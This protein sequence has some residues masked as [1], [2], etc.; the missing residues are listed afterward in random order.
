VTPKWTLGAFVEATHSELETTGI[1]ERLLGPQNYFLSAVGVTSTVDFRD[2]P[3]N[4]RHGWLFANSAE[5]N[6]IATEYAFTRFTSRY[7]YYHAIGRGLLAF[8]VRTGWIIP[9]GD[10]SEVPIDLRYFNGGATTVR[11]FAER[12]L[13]PRD[14]HGVPVG[15]TWY[16]VA[17]LEYDFPITGALD[18]AVFA[19]AGNLF[20]DE[21]P[22]LN[23]LRFAIGVGLRYRLPIG[24]LRLDYGINPAPRQFEEQGALH[25]S[26]GFAF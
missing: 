8:G 19:D 24:P 14:R 6:V 15:G 12:E 4:P 20:N 17:N 5:F 22:N 11:S 23:D 16:T 1:E 25:L 26:F 7:S 9:A 18:G 3:L 13:G 10:A 21:A 2:D